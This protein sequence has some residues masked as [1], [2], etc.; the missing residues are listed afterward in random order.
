MHER[1]L[2]FLKNSA[3]DRY[4]HL[5]KTHPEIIQQ[6]PLKIIA[7]Y[8]GVTNSSLSRIRRELS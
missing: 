5:L 1:M 3:E 2:A 4:L 8:I 6:V 7:S